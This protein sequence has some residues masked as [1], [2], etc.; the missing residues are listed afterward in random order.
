MAQVIKIAEFKVNGNKS[1]AEVLS[2][3]EESNVFARDQDGFISRTSTKNADGIWV[4]FMLWEDQKSV[5]AA[6]AKFSA[7]VRN[8]NLMAMLDGPSFKM[9]SHDIKLTS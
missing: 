9:S 6:G 5:E 7:D 4:E 8:G 1:D 3:I 2:A